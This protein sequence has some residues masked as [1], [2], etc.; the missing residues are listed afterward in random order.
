[1]RRPVSWKSQP[2]ADLLQSVYP[3]DALVR[4]VKGAVRLDCQAAL[5][6][7]NSFEFYPAK[8]DGA[9]VE[10]AR[11]SRRKAPAHRFSGACDAGNQYLGGCRHSTLAQSDRGSRDTERATAVEG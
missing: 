8:Q 3:Q 1:M 2:D 7:A 10:T 5:S 6:I 4:S 9:A 11:R